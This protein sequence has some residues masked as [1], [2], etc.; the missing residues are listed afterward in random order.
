MTTLVQSRSTSKSIIATP[1]SKSL[2]EITTPGIETPLPF[3]ATPK[4]NRL[5]VKQNT[6]S[7]VIQTPQE[8]F[9]NESD[10]YHGIV[11]CI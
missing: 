11:C 6:N 9:L 7:I 3:D 2:K 5:S 8:D 10:T 1:S 4:R